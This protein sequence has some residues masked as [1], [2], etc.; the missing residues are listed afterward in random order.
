MLAEQ[1]Y[2]QRNMVIEEAQ[3]ARTEHQTLLQE[4]S[5][6]SGNYNAMQRQVLEEQSQVNELK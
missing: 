1:E 6:A 4:M 5:T 3:R 2:A